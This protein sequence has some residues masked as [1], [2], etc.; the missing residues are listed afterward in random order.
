MAKTTGRPVSA[1]P[2]RVKTAVT[3]SSEAYRRLRAACVAEG[4]EQGELIELMINRLLSG[5]VVSVRGER[6]VVAEGKDRAEAEAEGKLRGRRRPEPWRRDRARK[7][8]PVPR[9]PFRR[10]ETTVPRGPRSKSWAGARGPRRRAGTTV[11]R[12]PPI[13]CQAGTNRGPPGTMAVSKW[14]YPIWHSGLA[15]SLIADLWAL[16]AT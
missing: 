2:S 10:E 16:K 1:S 3:I 8:N 4:L 7:S 12:G 9:G 6:F 15:E 14:V 5:Y 11:P 13:L